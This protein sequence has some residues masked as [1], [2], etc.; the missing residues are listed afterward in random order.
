MGGGEKEGGTGRE[1]EEE[2]GDIG[3]GRK[4]W[5]GTGRGAIKGKG[6][7]KEP[8]VIKRKGKG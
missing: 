3:V 4:R 5:Y 2:V 8:G 6:V 1:G 7:L